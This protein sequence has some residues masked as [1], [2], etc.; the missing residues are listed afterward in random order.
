MSE[1]A[2]FWIDHEYDRERAGDGISRYGAH[3]RANVEEFADSWGDIAPV[4]FACTSWRLAT[5]PLLSPGYVR[6]HRRILDAT[7]V[8]N[9]WD[10]SLITRVRLISPWPAAITW[11]RDWWRDLDWQD[12]PE[13]FG[14]FV[15]PAERDLAK[16]PYLRASL[17]VEAPVPLADLPAAPDGPGQDVEGTARRAVIV[18]VKE[19][20]E[21][22]SPIIR[23]LDARPGTP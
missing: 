22:I 19:L 13:V 16:V 12:W 8:R 7:C 23:Q 18:L 21:L 10:G 4:E 9:S 14:Q 2:A 6:R 20:N 15:E 11:P 5:T 3:V 1:H 17:L